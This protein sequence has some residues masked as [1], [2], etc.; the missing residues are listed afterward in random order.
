MIQTVRFAQIG[1]RVH[2]RMDVRNAMSESTDFRTRRFS[3]QAVLEYL[4]AEIEADAIYYGFDF[5]NGWDQVKECDIPII[6]AYGEW[7]GMKRVR[8]RIEYG[9]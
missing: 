1:G 9:L 5:R 2:Y 6:V 4:D 3:K 7:R 8:E